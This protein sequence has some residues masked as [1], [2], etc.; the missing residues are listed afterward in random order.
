L[1][2]AH[3]PK[4]SISGALMKIL[5]D[6]GGRRGNKKIKIH[7]PGKSWMV[8]SA[9]SW[10]KPTRG[11]WCLCAVP[12]WPQNT[13]CP[14]KVCAPGAASRGKTNSHAR[15][16]MARLEAAQGRVASGPSCRC[17]P[18]QSPLGDC[19]PWPAS[20]VCSLP[21]QWQLGIC[22]PAYYAVQHNSGAPNIS[23]WGVCARKG[24]FSNWTP[25]LVPS[26]A[27]FQSRACGCGLLGSGVQPSVR[28]SLTAG[29]LLGV[30]RIAGMVLD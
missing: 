27:R 20:S 30:P 8:S 14:Q 4:T 11:S 13:V 5:N 1:K 23:S 16:E 9:E 7:F 15:D 24:G 2:L 21:H 6:K 28:P 29:V 26:P 25:K 18:C 22:L 10:A 3:F 12:D 19:K 17:Q